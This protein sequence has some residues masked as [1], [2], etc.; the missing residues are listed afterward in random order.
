M[1]REFT[2]FVLNKVKKVKR[3]LRRTGEGG[4]TIRCSRLRK[5]KEKGRSLGVL[6]QIVA[7]WYITI[8]TAI[9]FTSDT[10]ASFNDVEVIENS[11][12][13]EWE[14]PETE[15]WDKSSLSF[16]NNNNGGNNKRGTSNQNS[17][18]EISSAI[19]NGKDSRDM[20]GPVKYEI[21]YAEK[22]NPKNGTV[23][24]TGEVPALK[25]G[26]TFQ[27]EY[28]PTENGKYMFKAYQRPNH[29]GAGELWSEEIQ[30]N[31]CSSEDSQNKQ[32]IEQDST[33]EQKGQVEQE[34]AEEQAEQKAE[35][36]EPEPTQEE[37]AVEEP[38]VIQENTDTP[39][40][41]ETKE[42]D[43]VPST[44]EKDDSNKKED[45]PQ[46]TNSIDEDTKKKESGKKSKE[47]EQKPKPTE[48][49]S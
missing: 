4:R 12:H 7:I 24:V 22:G 19:Q 26:E 47:E 49:D 9:Y 17:C 14:I 28:Q 32:S 36:K 3:L 40:E 10:G 11:L 35:Q 25:S 37:G 1:K 13:T 23:V 18:L 31:G 33:E 48:G 15:E 34:P 45:K 43:P 5:F 2:D 44:P 27:P 39:N 21:Y 38:E 8:F 30:V 16:V 29:P 6:A 42:P 46:A 20:Q 41:S